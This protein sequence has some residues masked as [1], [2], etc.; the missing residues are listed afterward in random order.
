M[1]TPA[2]A[3][4]LIDDAFAAK[5][6]LEVARQRAHEL[7]TPD[8]VEVLADVIADRDMCLERCNALTAY[9]DEIH[10]MVGRPAVPVVEAVR[11]YCNDEHETK[12]TLRSARD[13]ASNWIGK[14]AVALGLS[15]FAPAVAVRDRAKCLRDEVARLTAERDQLKARLKA[16]EADAT[17]QRTAADNLRAA[18]DR[19]AKAAGVDA[20]G[21]G[22]DVAD[23]VIAVLWELKGR[24]VLTVERLADALRAANVT[25]Q[26][27]MTAFAV[28]AAMSHVGDLVL[29]ESPTARP[30]ALP[31]DLRTE[32]EE[33]LRRLTAIP[34]DSADHRRAQLNRWLAL[35]TAEVAK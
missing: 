16:A 13:A 5:V 31:A 17:T 2:D 7:L 21:N 29:P 15:E 4:K 26:P 11:R 9:L 28:M 3:N 27:T 8:P 24:P 22:F 34:G 18:L 30:A 20:A 35:Q 14:I 32:L 6:A 12:N 23:K 1:T 10:G 25:L 19:V 33:D